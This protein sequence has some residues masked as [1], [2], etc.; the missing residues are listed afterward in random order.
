[1]YTLPY[2]RRHQ[3]YK[4]LVGVKVTKPLQCFAVNTL[5]PAINVRLHCKVAVKM[6]HI[7]TVN[8]V[9]QMSTRS[10]D[11]KRVHIAKLSPSLRLRLL[12]FLLSLPPSHPPIHPPIRTSLNLASDNI[13]AKSKV[14]YLSE[15]GL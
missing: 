15:L 4:F 12:Y 14:A 13:T 6:K 8:M 1:M 2:E 9:Q 5:T 10:C 11:M 3:V 7:K